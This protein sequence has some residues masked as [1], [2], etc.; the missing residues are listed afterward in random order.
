MISVSKETEPLSPSA[1][2]VLIVDDERTLLYTFSNSLKAYS[3]DLNILTAENG[4]HAVDILKSGHVDLVVTDLKMPEMD[5]FQLLIHMKKHYPG[6]P[7]IVMTAV[8]S[9]EVAD[10]LKA[11]GGGPYL[12]KPINIKDLALKIFQGIAAASQGRICGVTLAGFLQLIVMEGKTCALKIM[13]GEKSGILLI[14]DGELIDAK[15]EDLTGEAAACEIVTWDETEI[16]MG[17]YTGDRKKKIDAA[18]GEILLDAFRVKDERDRAARGRGE[19]ADAV[20]AAD[21]E[22]RVAVDNEPREEK[23]VADAVTSGPAQDAGA[24]GKAPAAAV[25]GGDLRDLLSELSKLQGVSAACLA[26]CDGFLIDSIFNAKM[27]DELVGAIAS[28][29]YGASESIGRELGRGALQ[30]TMLEFEQGAV[31]IAPVGENFLLVVMADKD[32]NLGML[33]LKIRKLETEFEAAADAV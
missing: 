24:G 33:R 21:S 7:V 30:L 16:K 11:M 17:N 3:P 13:S 25:R 23:G 10:R 8:G 27:E 1:K 19:P 4:L 29:G 18:M 22:P 32:T 12:E 2:S 6:I 15:T 14:K 20:V 26:G 9:P 28:A 31:I 5:G